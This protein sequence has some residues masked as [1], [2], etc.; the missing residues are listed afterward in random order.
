MKDCPSGLPFHLAFRADTEASALVIILNDFS[1]AA[2]LEMFLLL[3]S[4]TSFLSGNP[5]VPEPGPYE[6][7]GK[8][9]SMSR[10]SPE[11]QREEY[12]IPIPAQEWGSSVCQEAS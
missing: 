3:L 8:G 12:L 4:P 1:W 7:G 5:T 11:L 6:G 9:S 2:L 10:A